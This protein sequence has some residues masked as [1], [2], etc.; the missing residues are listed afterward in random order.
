[1]SMRLVMLLCLGIFLPTRA[2]AREASEIWKAQCKSCHGA[3][4]KAKTKLGEKEKIPDMTVP[5][6]QK[7]H[8]DPQIRDVIENGSKQN[9]KMKAFK[10]KLS[11]AEL[12][13]LVKY[14]RKLGG[15]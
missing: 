5:A 13:A 6:W 8:S 4:G 7:A 12:D 11:P 15:K 10:N 14:I 1:M 9:P 2:L 3:D